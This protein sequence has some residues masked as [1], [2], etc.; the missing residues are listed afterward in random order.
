MQRRAS[1][2]LLIVDHARRKIRLVRQ[3]AGKPFDIALLERRGE[4]DRERV[5]AS[6]DT[7][8]YVHRTPRSKTSHDQR[9]QRQLGSYVP[10]EKEQPSCPNLSSW[11]RSKSRRESA[12]RWCHC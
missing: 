3:E 6:Q 4:L 10:L 5:I 2:A 11:Q 8:R 7:A 9:K 12:I 1:A